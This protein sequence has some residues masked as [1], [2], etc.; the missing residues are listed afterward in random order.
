[1]NQAKMSKSLGNVVNTEPLVEMFGIDFV[2]FYILRDGPL[3]LDV[4]FD[5]ALLTRRINSDLVNTLGNLI[6]R[7]TSKSLMEDDTIIKNPF[8]NSIEALSFL[9]RTVEPEEAKRFCNDLFDGHLPTSVQNLIEEEANFPRAIER[10]MRVLYD[11]IF[12][13]L[14]RYS[15]GLFYF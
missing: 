2:R 4:S 10:V 13:F 8:G 14:F 5:Q 3:H 6:S 12:N 1:M 11:G 15:I 9:E 7:A